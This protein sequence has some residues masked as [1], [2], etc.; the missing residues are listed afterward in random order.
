MNKE[1]EAVYSP[2]IQTG[3][4]YFFCKLF[5]E[6]LVAAGVIVLLIMTF[7][8]VFA[9][10]IS[11]HN[12]LGVDIS[13][14]LLPPSQAHPLGTDDVGRDIFSRIIFG[15]RIS[16]ETGLLVALGSMGL[17][18]LVGL[19]TGYWGGIFDHIVMRVFDALMAFPGILLA[20]GIMAVLGPNS[21]NVVVA[22]IVAFIPS[23]TRLVRGS[24]LSVKENTYIESARS[25]GLTDAEILF[26]HVL[27]NCLA[28]ILVQVT[29]IFVFAIRA[30]AS[31]SFLGL[32]TPVPQPSWGNILA[33]GRNYL[34]DAPWISIFSGLAIA[35]TILSL[36]I[37][38]DALR[39]IIDPR[40]R[41]KGGD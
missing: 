4:K 39:D 36:N 17:G 6:K 26:R 9:Q 20:I 34:R 35:I 32:G 13:S 21:M 1:A 2:R 3:W 29:I 8:D 24:V 38:G 12:P 5:S 18:T 33:E 40:M 37:L 31:L 27:P 25:L 15:A 22:L 28:P 30:E 16:L 14:R 41:G 11:P 10:I 23:F 19:V 7:V